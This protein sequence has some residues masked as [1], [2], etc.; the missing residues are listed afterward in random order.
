MPNQL[1]RYLRLHRIPILLG[2]ASMVFY[3]TFAY[4]LDRTDF[5]KLFT[6]FAALFF[7][8]YKLIRFEKWNFKFLLGAGIIFRLLFLFAEPNLSPDFYRIIWDGELLR[9]SIDPYLYLPK[10]LIAQKDLLIPNTQELYKGMGDLNTGHYSVYPPL[11]QFI[12]AFIT[13]LGG[14]S[15]VG[16]IIALRTLI[17]LA[18]IGILYF[19]RKLLKNLNASP[20]LIFWY[21]LN[22]LVIIELTGHLHVEGLMLFFLIG[23]LYLLSVNKYRMAAI[24][25]AFSIS[26]NWVPLLFLP[27]FLNYLGFRKVTIFY[28]ITGALCVLFWL[29]FYSPEF[30]DHYNNAVKEW[31]SNSEFNAGIYNLIEEIAV[32]QEAKYGAVI[33]GYGKILPY[34]ILGAVL[35]FSFFGRNKKLQNL[36][37]NMLLVLALYYFL[38]VTVHPW[39][40]VSPMLLALFTKYRFAL[41]W[42]VTATLSYFAYSQGGFKENMM[43]LFIE[44]I[45]VFGFLAY[46]LID[47]KGRSLLFPKK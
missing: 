9:N 44:Y 41:V 25:Y 16:S 38:S 12:F 6:L 26:I 17:G 31:F 7:L 14:K 2:L 10:D 3:V 11:A 28:A 1:S 27:L 22:P 20:H 21:F 35:L 42:S 30:F 29:P 34:I 5:I 46:E 33:N 8:C 47:L 4:H 37:T 45:T 36:I 23:S 24:A 15:I 43:V 19:G 13:L 40:I 39:H 18:D 32:G